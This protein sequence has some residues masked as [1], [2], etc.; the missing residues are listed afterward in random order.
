M[1]LYNSNHTVHGHRQNYRKFESHGKYVATNRHSRLPIV[2]LEKTAFTLLLQIYQM[3]HN[4]S[5]LHFWFE[6]L[7]FD[8]QKNSVGRK[9][10]QIFYLYIIR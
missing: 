2:I 5:F 6:N 3:F 10:L 9:M 1:N 7:D 8:F 4:S